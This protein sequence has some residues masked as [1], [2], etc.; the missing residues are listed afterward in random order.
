MTD[1]H[2][3][4]AREMDLLPCPFCGAKP[5]STIVA[6]GGITFRSIYCDAEACV[7]PETGGYPEDV[8]IARWNR[9]H[10]LRA[11]EQR[12]WREAAEVAREHGEFCRN[13]AQNGGSHDLY[14]RSTGAFYLATK[15][16]ARADEEAGG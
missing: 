12:I 3:A 13:E 9:R 7:Q 10:A 8:S 2:S 11:T 14:E 15:F 16:R 6:R 1:E 4:K 5:R